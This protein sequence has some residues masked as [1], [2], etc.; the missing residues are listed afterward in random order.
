MVSEYSSFSIC[1]QYYGHLGSDG[2]LR[3]WETSTGNLKQEYIPNLHLTSPCTCMTWLASPNT[4][5]SHQPRKKRKSD[6]GGGGAMVAMGTRCGTVVLY[7]VAEGKVVSM[8][9]GH[10]SAVDCLVWERDTD[11]FSCASSELVIQWDFVKKKRKRSFKSGIE[12]ITAMQVRIDRN[13]LLLA[14][15]EIKLWDLESVTLIRVYTGH[16]NFVTSLDIIDLPSGESYFI[17]SAQNDRLLKAWNLNKENAPEDPVASFAMNDV[18][19]SVSVSVSK[20][21]DTN[22]AAVTKSGAMLLYSHQIN[23]KNVPI[24]PTQVVM[25]ASDS[26]QNRSKVSSLQIILARSITKK[27]AFIAYGSM[28]FLAFES[29]GLETEDKEICLVRKDP[30]IASSLK[31]QAVKVRG[32]EIGNDVEYLSQSN[33]NGTIVGNKRAKG[34]ASDV[35]LAERLDNLALNQP[36][37]STTSTQPKSEG[38]AHLLIQGL[39]SKD[40]SLLQSVLFRKDEV[41][42]AQTVQRLPLHVISPLLRE[43]TALIQGKTYMSQVAAEW[44]RAILSAHASQLLADT[45]TG[46]LL[47]PLLGIVE[48]RLGTLGPL[49]RLRGR[50]DLLI[51][52]VTVSD[53]QNLV[54][55]SSQALLV[56][57]DQGII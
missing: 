10:K 56:H 54:D 37:S 26:G 21:G 3:I 42:M 22:M 51:N 6:G 25:I 23:G 17:T 5:I 34:K 52:Q 33:V 48:S 53:K 46:P 50:L 41:V 36:S 44:L 16:V 4:V 45:N 9:Q 55:S 35:P 24:K 38:L 18:A 47:A 39:Q 11:L 30:K 43:L 15:R 20:K 29:I 27:K 13:C 28:P 49:C 32:P 40:K 8:L 19:R 1:G 12:Q 7:S 31:Q 14:S 57:H 2:K